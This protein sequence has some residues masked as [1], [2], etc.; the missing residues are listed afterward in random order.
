[1]SRKVA[2]IPEELISS[3]HLQKPELRVEEDIVQL[4]DRNKLPDDMKV[5]LLSQLITRYHKTVHE[6]P[7]PVKVSIASDKESTSEA[8]EELE[9]V[10]SDPIFNDIIASV[11]R[12]YQKYVPMIMEKLKTRGYFWNDAGELVVGNNRVENSRIVDFFAYMLRS[13]KTLT[14]PLHFDVFWKAIKKINIPYSWIANKK[15]ISRLK[16]SAESPRTPVSNSEKAHKRSS[17]LKS[18][19]LSAQSS[20]DQYPPEWLASRSRSHSPQQKWLTY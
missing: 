4:L 2:F 10:Y 11:S 19:Q 14:E 12:T 13:T 7:E 16:T 8:P 20:D 15:L 1:M 6:E 9:D 5:K 3:Y 17:R 18:R